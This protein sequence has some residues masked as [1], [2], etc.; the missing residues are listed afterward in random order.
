MAKIPYLHREDADESA[1][2]LY[3][4]LEK[5]RK[6]PIPNVFLALVHAPEQ[7]DALLTYT[8]SLRRC[9]LSPR[10]RELLILAV[11]H[12]TGC[13]YEIAHHR[14]YALAAGL[15]PEQIASV[16]D[17]ENAAVFDEFDRA[18]IRLATA[19][20]GDSDVALQAWDDVAAELTTKQMVQLMLTL[21][22]YASSARMMRL[23]DIDLEDGYSVT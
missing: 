13:D 9:D 14:P 3:D 17:F 6:K 15:T 11:G 19:F 12:A 1:Q 7:V 23:I 2:P 10:I 21:T 16:P 22:W 5:E 4:R 8:N 18:L 20:S